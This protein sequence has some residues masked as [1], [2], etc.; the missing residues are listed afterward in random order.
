VDRCRRVVAIGDRQGEEEQ[1]HVRGARENEGSSLPDCSGAGGAT[2]V[3]GSVGRRFVQSARVKV[4]RETAGL[5]V[6]ASLLSPSRALCGVEPGQELH[7]TWGRQTFYDP[8]FSVM[9]KSNFIS[10]KILPTFFFCGE[11]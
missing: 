5:V 11:R 2:A 9:K 8:R 10:K 4:W 3:D 6:S 7:A 1:I